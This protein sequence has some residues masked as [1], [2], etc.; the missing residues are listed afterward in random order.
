MT[1]TQAHM[2]LSNR[3][4]LVPV[5][6]TNFSSICSV[7]DRSKSS[8]LDQI[9]RLKTKSTSFVNLNLNLNSFRTWSTK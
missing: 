4:T 3:R 6:E 2:L 1:H 5:G 7:R 9:E 8:K